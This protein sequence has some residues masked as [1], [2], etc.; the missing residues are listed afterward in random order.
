MSDISGINGS[1][2]IYSKIASGKAINSA[3]DGAAE[4]SIIE[5]EQT[6][7][8][9]LNA[10]VRNMESG[11][12]LSNIEDGALA[13]IEEHLQRI[14]ELGVQASN[15]ILADEDKQAIQDEINQ[16]KQGINDIATQTNYNGKSLLDGSSSTMRVTTD[17][18]GTSTTVSGYNATTDSLGI[19]SFDVTQDFDLSAIDKAISAVSS[20]RSSIGAKTNALEYSIN[21]SKNAAEQTLSAQSKLEDLDIGKAVSEKKKNEVLDQYKLMLQKKKEDDD[22]TTARNLFKTIDNS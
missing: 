16:L 22:E 15:G 17:S 18:N 19:S 7:S 14:R 12:D 9:G 5:K 13:G 2:N 1:N 10:G 8:G 21:Y 20:T 3:A 4:L 6:Q 11:I